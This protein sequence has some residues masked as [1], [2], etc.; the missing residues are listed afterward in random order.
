MSGEGRE[1][2]TRTERLNDDGDEVHWLAAQLIS[3][4]L[5]ALLVLFFSSL[6]HPA[7]LLLSCPASH[8]T[9][10]K[11]LRM[12]PAGLSKKKLS[13]ARKMCRARFSW[14]RCEKLTADS[15]MSTV[16]TIMSTC[17]PRMSTVC[18][19]HAS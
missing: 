17:A 18:R 3:S 15:D 6:S 1:L 13:G 12:R 2:E 14:I 8:P 16:C 19:D 5:P 11:R 7:A 9:L 10:A 4:R